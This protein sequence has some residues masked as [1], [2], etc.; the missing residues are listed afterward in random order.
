MTTTRWCVATL[1]D[2]QTHLAD[3]ADNALVTAQCDGK[4]FQ[5]LAILKGTP[6]DPEQICPTCITISI[7][8][9]K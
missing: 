8:Q 5:P 2:G 4:Q 9:G 3:P 6:L 1:A 7:T